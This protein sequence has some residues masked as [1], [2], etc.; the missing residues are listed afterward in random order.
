MSN[1]LTKLRIDEVSSV[2]AGAARGARVLLVKHDNRS[3]NMSDVGVIGVAKRA[4]AAIAKGEIDQTT[5]AKLQQRLALEAWPDAPT[6]GHALN[7]FFSSE[8]GRAMLNA[9]LQ[10]NYEATQKRVASGNAYDVLKAK[11]IG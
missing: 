7:R 3:E 8:A 5:F 11:G 2:I 6:L 10:A 1:R 9:G 4:S